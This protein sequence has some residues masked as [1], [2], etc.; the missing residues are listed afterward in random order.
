[1]KELII[2]NKQ[3]K[4]AVIGLGYVGLTY[5]L[6]LNSLGYEVS[7]IDINKSTLISLQNGNLPFFEEN[8]EGYLKN[9]IDNDLLQL[10][11]VDE[12]MKFK[13]KQNIIYIVTVGTPVFQEEINTKSLNN[14]FSFLKDKLNDEDA[15]VLRSTVPLGFTK[16]YCEMLSTK[17]FYCFAPERTIEGK[18]IIE[19]STL[20]QIFGCDHKIHG[21]FFD[22]IFRSFSSEVVKVE[23]SK[24]AEMIKLTSNVYRDV[25]F[26]FSNEIS[27][28]SYN[29]GI[30]P[31]SVI[32][33]CNY[34]YPRCNI[35]SSGPVAGPCLSKDSY[36]LKQSINE[37]ITK[38]I[39]L[40]SRRLNEKYVIDILSD[41]ISKV[42]KSSILG[43]SFK[44]TPPTNDIR[45]SFA[46]SLN[47][48]LVDKNIN[49]VGY[50]PLVYDEDFDSINLKRAYT[51]EEA[52]IDK[53]LIIIQNNNTIFKR[54]DIYK[55]SKLT[56]E[57]AVILDLWSLHHNIKLYNRKYIAL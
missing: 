36:I 52:F 13:P 57:N 27:L 44:G 8:L 26:G 3:Y 30:N 17:I 14:V 49:V 12:Y 11:H 38:S 10:F 21:D 55:L 47:N 50:D 25:I 15:V 51:L 9:S 6:Y 5:S 19:L 42:K 34:K 18:A 7:G 56:N 33:S 48:Y 54:M 22:K 39:I 35:Y 20:P 29:N 37:S 32:D 46:I 1:M 45:D 43:V 41:L 40:S 53:D 16:R 4:V 24:T 28:I 23:N 31:K 2:N